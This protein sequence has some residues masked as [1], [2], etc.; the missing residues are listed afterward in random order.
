MFN[1]TI[2]IIYDAG[3]A[4]GVSFAEGIGAAQSQVQ[5]AINQMGIG[6]NNFKQ[7]ALHLVSGNALANTVQGIYGNIPTP[8]GSPQ[9]PAIQNQPPSMSQ[10]PQGAGHTFIQNI[11]KVDDI[12]AEYLVGSYGIMKAGVGA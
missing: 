10:P 12:T 1:G 8:G 7:G 11:Y 3:Q 9:P 4:V 6:L 5:G 2:D